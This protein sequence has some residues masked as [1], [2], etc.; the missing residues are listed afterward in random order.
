[1]F[2]K[3]LLVIILCAVTAAPA[4]AQSSRIEVSGTFGWTFSDGVP[5]N[6]MANGV[7]YTK[8]EPKD[9]ASIGLS[10]GV[11]VTPQAEIEFLW[12]RQM[13]QLEVS[14][15]TTVLSAD[16]NV[17]NYH[18]NFIYNF[19]DEDLVVRPFLLVGIGAT[20]FGQAS[21]NGH[22]SDGVTKFSWAIGGGIKAYPSK[23][24][25]FKAMM[26][27]TPNYIKTEGAGWWCDPWWGCY[28][29]GNPYYANQFEMSGGVTLRF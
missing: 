21:Y 20:N 6:A 19:G 10:F 8:V 9:S 27:W 11:Y 2:R 13:S 5:V 18:G 15:P 17:D 22:T 1:M 14:G 12:N 4:F 26:R 3:V 25:G 24:V 28:P 7:S 23:H 16:M 29:V